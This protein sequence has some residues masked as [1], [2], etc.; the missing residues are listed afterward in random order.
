MPTDTEQ[1]KGILFALAA[2]GMW[3][4]VP[5]YFKAVDHVSPFEVVAHRVLWSVAF[6]AIFIVATGRWQEFTRYLKQHRLVAGLLLSAIIISLNWLVFIW[7]VGQG[8]ILEAALG[9]FINPLISVLLGMIFLS[10]RLRRI[11]WLAII[12][13]AIGVGYQLVL[14]G[15]L[16][17]VALVLAFSFG[18]YGLLRKR[19]TV[20]PFSGLL[21]E[22]LLLSPI[23]LAYLFWLAQ[24]NALQF[25]FTTD[26]T[27]L[28]LIA[29]GLVTSLPLICFA[30]GA[31]RLTL[32]LNGL[33]QYIAP[34]IAFLL[35][36]FIYNEPLDGNKLITFSFIWVGLIFFTLESLWQTKGK[37][38]PLATD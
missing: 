4:L 24:Q 1:R 27:T 38:I 32:T 17:W 22:T 3:G 11:Q 13:A 5:I 35:A 37:A 6:L 20:D 34:S 36:V 29:S 16:P 30:A 23:A 19:L 33:L 25:Q 12:L 2:Y 15:S 10:E 7:A 9:Y 18:F 26:A 28:L 14:L 8:R 31:R 21:I